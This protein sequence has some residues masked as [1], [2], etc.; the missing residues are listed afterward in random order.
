MSSRSTSRASAVAGALGAGR[1]ALVLLCGA[2]P[3]VALL[4]R[5]SERSSGELLVH[6]GR[7]VLPMQL[8]YSTAVAALATLGGLLL[9][10]GGIGCALFAFP[11]R[12][13]LEKLLYL[14]L[15]VPTWYLAEL[16]RDRGVLDGSGGLVVVLAVTG[17]P[18]FQ[19]FA[20]AALGRLPGRYLDQLVLSHRARPLAVARALLPLALPALAAA[21]AL[22]LLLAWSDVASARTMAVPTLTVGL[23]DQWFGR[24]D[25]AAGSL[26]ALTLLALSLV[27]A[28]LLV[29]RLERGRVQDSA[30]LAPGSRRLRLEGAAALLP[31]LL[32]APQLA[33]GLV[34]PGAVIG[35]WVE[36]RIA[37]V[38]LGL[39]AGDL[40]RTLLTAAGAALL[41]ALLALPLLHA[42]ALAGTPRLAALGTRLSLALFA[43]PPAVLGIAFLVLLADGEGG[44]GW[45]DLLNASPL[46]LALAIG[47]HFGAVF[48]AAGASALERQAGAHCTLLRSLGRAGALDSLW[49]LRP[50]LAGPL[51]AAA[52]FVALEGMKEQTLTVLLQPF[53]WST[54]STRVFQYAQTQQ[55]HDCAVWIL[56]LAIAGLY[57]LLTLARLATGGAAPEAR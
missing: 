22:V 5:A 39:L 9:A 47:L 51:L 11:G 49:L 10:A 25:D 19:L 36:E 46:P 14:P 52:A 29:A 7:T 48:V 20:S 17:A 44:G 35:L 23:F 28:L 50:Y 41:A 30:R 1:L 26:H 12:A 3:L 38:D 57:P 27:P 33:L 56:C 18:L 13:A 43:L 16:Y 21:A 40:A 2:A 6:L 15:L 42:R 8:G 32:S 55:L 4:A 37:R 31:W 53:G 24:E 54:V 45:L 34:Y